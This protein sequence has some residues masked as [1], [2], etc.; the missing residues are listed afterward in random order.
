MS[1]LSWLSSLE[2]VL[3]PKASSTLFPE[4]E[5]EINIYLYL[6]PGLFSPA[7]SSRQQRWSRETLQRILVHQE[8]LYQ[9]NLSSDNSPGCWI[10]P[11]RL[12]IISFFIFPRITTQGSWAGFIFYRRLYSRSLSWRLCPI[13]ELGEPRVWTFGRVARLSAGDG[14]IRCELS[15][16]VWC[17]HLVIIIV[18]CHECVVTTSASHRSTW[19][20]YNPVTAAQCSVI[21]APISVLTPA[22]LLPPL[23]SKLAA[24]LPRP[25]SSKYNHL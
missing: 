18:T 5:R 8:N 20:L 14:T 21:T 16:S 13:S 23:S 1:P 10:L 3:T 6:S 24:S 9:C 7:G 19:C 17:W 4:S 22:P 12:N 11:W 15:S 25:P 2:W